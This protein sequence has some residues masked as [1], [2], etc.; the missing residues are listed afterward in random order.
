ML[1]N[2]YLIIY[3]IILEQRKNSPTKELLKSLSCHSSRII[4]IRLTTNIAIVI[5]KIKTI[6]NTINNLS[7][8]FTPTIKRIVQ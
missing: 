2:K 7:F 8:S 1:I 6:L 5:N 4:Y 3:Y